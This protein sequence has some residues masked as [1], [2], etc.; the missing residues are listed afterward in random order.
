VIY[1]CDILRFVVVVC[2]AS[3]KKPIDQLVHNCNDNNGTVNFTHW[4]E[5]S[6]LTKNQ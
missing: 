6:R 2:D 1:D 4:C 3:K 5:R